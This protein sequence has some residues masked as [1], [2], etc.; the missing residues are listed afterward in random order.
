[1]HLLAC[2]KG[3]FRRHRSADLFCGGGGGIMWTIWKEHNQRT[4]EWI[5]RSPMEIKLSFLCSMYDWMAALSGH[6]FSSLEEFL[7]ICNFR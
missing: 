4:F 7:D 6:S 3:G 2:W 5:K 1:M